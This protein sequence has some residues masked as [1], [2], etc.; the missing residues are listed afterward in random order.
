MD[1]EQ[2]KKF[3]DQKT[4]GPQYIYIKNFR[5]FTR[6]AYLE[7]KFPCAIVTCLSL[8]TVHDQSTGPDSDLRY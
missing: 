4:E 8:K 1:F 7:S 5:T 6:S 2:G 3:N